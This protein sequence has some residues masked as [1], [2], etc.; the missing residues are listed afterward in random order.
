VVN[1]L[2][3]K[4]RPCAFDPSKDCFLHSGRSA[5]DEGHSTDVQDLVV[6]QSAIN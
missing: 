1:G 5:E 6:D 4:K 3:T 2:R